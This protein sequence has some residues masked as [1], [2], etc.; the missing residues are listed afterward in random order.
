[1][2]EL[3]NHEQTLPT[4]LRMWLKDQMR[5]IE[6]KTLEPDKAVM[7]LTMLDEW[8]HIGHADEISKIIDELKEEKVKQL[9]E[10]ASMIGEM[11]EILRSGYEKAAEEHQALMAEHQALVEEVKRLGLDDDEEEDDEEEEEE[12]DEEEEELPQ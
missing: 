8:K 4:E 3:I 2:A 11:Y 6:N 10:R 12:E 9:E 5:A 7:I 1:M